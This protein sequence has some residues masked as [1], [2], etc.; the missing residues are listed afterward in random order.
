[1]SNVKFSQFAADTT[2]DS[3]TYLVGYDTITNLNIKTLASDLPFY[4]GSG[5]VGRVPKFNGAKSLGDSLISDSG[6][7]VK[8]TY[9]GN[10]VGINLDFANQTYQ[11][12]YIPQ[13]YGYYVNL[14]N[15]LVQI[16]DYGDWWGGAPIIKLTADGESSIETFQGF[17][18]AK[19]LSL[20]FT[21]AIYAIGDYGYTY[22]LKINLSS[23]NI[24]LGDIEGSFGSANWINI[25]SG[26]GIIATYQ[27]T[28]EKGLILNVA[29]DNYK[30]G[31]FNAYTDVYL[32]VY[33]TDLTNGYISTNYHGQE[34]GLKFD[35]ANYNF[36]FGDIPN[37]GGVAWIGQN[38]LK[39][40]SYDGSG[41]AGTAMY[42]NDGLESIYTQHSGSDKGLKLDFGNLTYGLGSGSSIGD[43]FWKGVLVGGADVKIGD[44]DTDNP[45]NGVGLQVSDSGRTITAYSN[46]NA[47]GLSLDFA[48]DIYKLGNF[49][50]G[51]SFQIESM[52]GIISTKYYTGDSGLYIDMGSLSGWF[53]LSNTFGFRYSLFNGVEINNNSL[54]IK[55]DAIAGTIKTSYNNIDRGIYLDFANETYFF[56]AFTDYGL[57]INATN[58]Q[59]SLG[60]YSGG[61]GSYNWINIDSSTGVIATYFDVNPTGLKLDFAANIY[62]LGD[63]NGVSNGTYLQVDNVNQLVSISKSFQ[64]ASPTGGTAKPWRLGNVVSQAVSL[65]VTRYVEVEIDGVLQK[66]ALITEDGELLTESGGALLQED[67]FFLLT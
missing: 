48:S 22:G 4:G 19:G 10:D 34:I 15:G 27:G 30:L 18:N 45:D 23:G 49:N 16:G 36:Y 42:I 33:Q 58:G 13:G 17:G 50:F 55:L 1:M 28:D 31:T 2:P 56:Q 52:V 54:N 20:N 40:G 35:F 38:L 53:G 5:T 61:Y 37:N 14:N 51:A 26:N 60:D 57:K 47:N 32:N 6:T 3:T 43:Q 25:D 66:L 12:G 9:G 11:L 39:L 64:T 29:N 44:F 8:T 7:V 65:D 59:I 21:N 24:S 63:I 62:W 41:N 67:S 46:F